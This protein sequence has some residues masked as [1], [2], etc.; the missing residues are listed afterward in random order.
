MLEMMISQ[1]PIDAHCRWIVHI[2]H[3]NVGRG[4]ILDC[5]VDPDYICFRL[6]LRLETLEDEVLVEGF[7]FE[8][9]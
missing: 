5:P 4:S 3:R 7:K 9:V 6:S 1:Y 2:S 8:I